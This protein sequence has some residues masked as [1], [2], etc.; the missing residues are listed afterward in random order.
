MSARK[1]IRLTGQ[2]TLCTML[3]ISADICFVPLQASANEG[4]AASVNTGLQPAAPDI[5]TKLAS[6][7][8]PETPQSKHHF[9]LRS[10]EFPALPNAAPGAATTPASVLGITSSSS[11]A[12]ETASKAEPVHDMD[13]AAQ[14]SSTLALASE[15]SNQA[16]LLV[17][18]FLL[19]AIGTM[20]V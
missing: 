10:V 4:K 2:Y 16:Q 5:V 15:T 14:Q 6:K 17:S 11:N 18:T 12:A 9:Q 7:P 8:Q 19:K 13:M 20:E 3:L 1:L